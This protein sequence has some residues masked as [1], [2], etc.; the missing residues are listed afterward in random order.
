MTK[1][2]ADDYRKE[3]ILHQIQS[4][5]GI[6]VVTLQRL[7]FPAAEKSSEQLLF[8]L[9]LSLR[10]RSGEFERWGKMFSY[11]AFFQQILS[12]AR[13]LALYQIT[14][15]DLPA[16]DED[17]LE[18]RKILTAALETGLAEKQYAEAAGQFLQKDHEDLLLSY[19]FTEEPFLYQIRK[20]LQKKIKTEAYPGR[21]PVS[22]T[23]RRALSV[24]REIEAIAQEICKEEKPCNIILCS[25]AAQMPVLKT[26]FARYGIPFSYTADSRVPRLPAAYRSLVYY[27]FRKDSSTL[28]EAAERSAFRVRI[29]AEL[30]AFLE[31]TMTEPQ[32]PEVYE[33]YADA[34]A[35]T[36]GRRNDPPRPSR[37]AMRISRLEE[38]GKQF[39]AVI[40]EDL[41][42]LGSASDPKDVLRNAY[43]VLTSSVLLKQSSELQAGL[44]LRSALEEC[45]P[46]VET[47]QDA[48]FLADQLAAQTQSEHALVTDFCTVTD[49]RHPVDPRSIT[50]VA[51]CSSTAYPGFAA[52]EGVFDEDYVRRI[53]KYPQLKERRGIYL[54]QLEWV[55]RSGSEIRF[56]CYT[57]DSL[58]REIF[59]AFE[60][61]SRSD[62][63]HQGILPVASL[64]PG[65]K[66]A[67]T[68]TSDTAR[69]LFTETDSEGKMIIQGSVSSVES[70]FS[71]PY[72]YFIASGLK[73]RT[74]DTLSPDAAA[75]GTIQHAVMENVI[76]KEDGMIDENY[77]E[78]IDRETVIELTA[79][80]F[81][82][83]KALYPHQT[84]YIDMT[85]ERMC[86][87]LLKSA[88]FLKEYEKNTRLKPYAAERPFR[89]SAISEHIRLRGTIDRISRDPGNHLFAILDYKSSSKDLSEKKVKQ[90]LQ[91][92]LLSYLMT[93]EEMYPDDEPVCAYYFSLKDENI[94][95]DKTD[96]V[97]L[98]RTGFKTEVRD[99]SDPEYIS[100]L[101]I[102][103]RQLKGW[104]LSGRT[105]VIDAGG[106]Y[107]SGMKKCFDHD[108]VRECLTACYEYFCR[109]L[110]GEEEDALGISIA[111]VKD[112]CTFCDYGSICR[113][114]G[115]SREPRD[116]YEGTLVKQEVKAE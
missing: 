45:L 55:V 40:R 106:R 23:Y 53:E 113:F 12:F 42:L 88:A 80:Y 98:S 87:S 100:S 3:S 48:L 6:E 54:E 114:H 21:E 44:S 29:S 46:L 109:Q 41:D 85:A 25:P 96:A 27:A 10:R 89:L 101:F 83:M 112:A 47:E 70:W 18:L 92:Q 76:Q 65:R 110:L 77:A 28:L 13:K 43:T 16:D 11:P 66:P 69:C 108:A 32:A 93:A 4:A 78:H 5:G 74:P 2:I 107:V 52:M 26:V 67:H 56:S 7:L 19:S 63:V 35:K 24:R 90:G 111:P 1:I 15:E 62:V 17:L 79:P 57:N 8:S 84:A 94:S 59:P 116:V 105:D 75:M 104:R 115:D 73:L 34:V 68:L 82:A 51:G 71:C 97:K 31:Q 33:N 95:S 64:S 91:L 72:R 20:E 14:P 50:Y 30:F 22:M 81:D 38:E 86:A 60:I 37:E 9:A 39:F 58:G 102:E 61:T 99:F 103:S 49:L 36:H